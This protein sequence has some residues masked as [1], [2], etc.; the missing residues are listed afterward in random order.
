MTVTP[1]PTTGGRSGAT[2]LDELTPAAEAV[3][4][5]KTYGNG[6]AEVRALDAVSVRFERGCFTAVMG[7]RAP[8]SPR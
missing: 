6:Q 8:A 1:T 3:A 2:E 7:R 4:I 5:T